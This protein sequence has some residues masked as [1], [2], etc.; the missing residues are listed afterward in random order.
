LAAGRARFSL[1]SAKYSDGQ[2]STSPEDA[3]LNQNY[4]KG[5]TTGS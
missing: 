2:Y 1:I 5:A 4:K 3:L